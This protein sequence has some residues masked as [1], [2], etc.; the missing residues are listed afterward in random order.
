VGWDGY[1][2]GKLAEEGVYVF[3]ISGTYNSGEKF[4]QVGSV[5]IIYNE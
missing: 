1:F 5:M 4:T 2:D 3:R